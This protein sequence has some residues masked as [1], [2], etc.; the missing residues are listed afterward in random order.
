MSVALTPIPTNLPPTWLT[1]ST[2]PE[3]GSNHATSVNPTLKQCLNRCLNRSRKLVLSTLRPLAISTPS[4]ST[5]FASVSSLAPVAMN[6]AKLSRASTPFLACLIL[7]QL[8][9]SKELPSPL[10][11][12][13]SPFTHPMTCAS[14]TPPLL[15]RQLLPPPF[16]SA[17]A[18]T[19]AQTTSP[20][21]NLPVLAT[22]SFVLSLRPPVSFFVRL[23]SMFY[24]TNPSQ[25]VPV[26]RLHPANVPTHSYVPLRS[27][28]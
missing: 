10:W 9:N 22:L 25:S 2:M 19:K 28:R 14:P 23:G 6:T 4:S 11:L 24:Q 8:E 7:P 1:P 16:T 21:E 15:H 27:S 18:L 5:G 3:N 20:S 13:I 12:V 17:F 26:P